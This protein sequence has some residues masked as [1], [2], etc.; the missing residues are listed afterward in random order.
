M[1]IPR[2]FIEITND[3]DLA[4]IHKFAEVPD[5]TEEDLLQVLQHLSLWRAR[6]T[7]TFVVKHC[8]QQITW[9]HFEN[10]IWALGEA[11]RQIL[12][13]KRGLRSSRKLFDRIEAICT[14]PQFGKGRESFTMLLGRYGG[15]ASIPTLMR[16]LDDPE[17]AG[18]AVYSLRLLGS[19]DATEKMRPFLDSPKAWVKQ[20]ARKYFQKVEPQS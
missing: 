8:G 9:I 1:P 5:L 3:L 17:V 14:D 18:Q 6:F 13:K 20:E 11:F 12:Q 15:K 19:V 10:L 2:E 4:K 16:L 7:A